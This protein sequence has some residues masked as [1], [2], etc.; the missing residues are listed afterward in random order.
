L[1]GIAISVLIFAFGFS[2]KTVAVHSKS[3]RLNSLNPPLFGFAVLMSI[4]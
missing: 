2:D 4:K 3:V 1:Y